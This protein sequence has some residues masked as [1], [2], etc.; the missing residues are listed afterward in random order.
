[1][2]ILGRGMRYTGYALSLLELR[3]ALLIQSVTRFFSF[4]VNRQDRYREIVVVC[5]LR[6]LF[7]ESMLQVTSKGKCLRCANRR[8]LH[9]SWYHK[10]GYS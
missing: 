9:I 3:R 8:I 2:F 4:S 5:K 10:I 6:S 1:M 7:G